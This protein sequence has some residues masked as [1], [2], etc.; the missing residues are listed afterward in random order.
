MPM[1]FPDLKALEMAAEVWKFRNRQE[2][3][4]EA[5]YRAALADH[6]QQKDRIEAQEIRT[7]KGWDQWTRAQNL[8]MLK[9]GL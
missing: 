2:N 6:V 5:E 3:E 9:R 1:D 8:D 4:T 7:G